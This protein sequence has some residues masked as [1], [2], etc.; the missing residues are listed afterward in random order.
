MLQL[1]LTPA[2][3]ASQAGRLVLSF[4]LGKEAIHLRQAVRQVGAL[5][6]SGEG[7][8]SQ[9]IAHLPPRE[10]SNSNSGRLTFLQGK[11]AVHLRQAGNCRQS[12]SFPGKE[13]IFPGRQSGRHS[14]SPW[15]RKQFFPGNCSPSS[16]GRKKQQYLPGNFP[17]AVP[18]RLLLTFLLGK[19]AILCQATAHLPP[20]EGSSSSQA[21]A[22]LPPGEGSRQCSSPWGGS[23]SQA[24]THPSLWG[25]KW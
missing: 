14:P 17:S 3:L 9:V 10:G 24:T 18:P 15:G 8:N 22:H 11:E 21:T 13:A 6:P 20:R 23:S 25:R 19:E 5:L 16:R 1:P 4:P 7:S 2:N 12:P